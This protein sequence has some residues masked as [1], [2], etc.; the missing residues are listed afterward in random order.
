LNCPYINVEKT[1]STTSVAAIEEARH[2]LPE[3]NE[4]RSQATKD[5]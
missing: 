5:I 2:K 3:S 4:V 1:E